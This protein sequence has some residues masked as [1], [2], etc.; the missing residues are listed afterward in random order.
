MT[1]IQANTQKCIK[2][3]KQA[4]VFFGLNDPDATPEPYCRKCVEKAKM[5]IYAE[6]A[7][8]DKKYATKRR[9]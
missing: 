1:K 6:I 7:K 5:R 3:G 9:T 8:I 2:C 4:N